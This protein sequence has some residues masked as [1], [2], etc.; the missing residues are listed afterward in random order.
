MPRANRM[1]D[2]KG[3]WHITHK[4][5]KQE[6]LLK[7]A[8]DRRM[9]CSWLFQARLR[10]GLRVLNYV[11]TSN[12]I[13]LMVWSD[14]KETVPSSI[15]LI[16]GRTAQNYNQRKNRRGAFWEDRYHAIPIKTQ[17]HFVECL[18]YV[19]LNMVRAGVVEHPS[20]WREAGFHE[21]QQP[22]KR[23]V[24][25][26]YDLLLSLSG[27]SSYAHFTKS[28]LS[29]IESKLQRGEL[30]GNPKWTTVEKEEDFS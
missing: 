21:I 4:C 12:H 20:H 22:R 1:F 19:D 24:V 11:V 13:H 25:I 15:Q 26:D 6:F 30:D 2:Y 3:V 27:C 23:Y 10:Y 17:A 9:W 14:D 16:A 5:H 7:F 28:H 18:V 29:W 8:R